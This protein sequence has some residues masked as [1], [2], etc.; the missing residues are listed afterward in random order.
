MSN[1]EVF[2]GIA[3]C[4]II[5]LCVLALYRFSKRRLRV[6]RFFKENRLHAI[7]KI[8]QDAYEGIDG[9]QA[10]KLARLHYDEPSL[11]YGEIEPVSFA[12]LLTLVQPNKGSVWIDLGS[13]VGKSV[14]LVA[15]LY[16]VQEAIG[17]EILPGLHTLAETAR[18]RLED[19]QVQQRIHFI[20]QDFMQ[21]NLEHAT[22]IFVN[23]AGF[24]GD[25][26]EQL[27]RLLKNAP[28]GC[29]VISI[30]RQLAIPQLTRLHQTRM[31]TSWGVSQVYIYRRD[32]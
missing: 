22:H 1:L 8:M 12:A 7:Q 18:S 32:P 27:E 20:C 4:S 17:V 3:G 5:A 11:T 23:A 9:F 28:I 15:L 29:W 25:H 30:T 31:Q 21:Y 16:P 2:F 13:G 10:S 14:L 24:F 19:Y 26:H 6:R